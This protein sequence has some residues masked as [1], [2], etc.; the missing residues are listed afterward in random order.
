MG[1]ESPDELPEHCPD[2]GESFSVDH[3][4]AC[5]K[6]AWI[7]KRHEEVKRAWKGLFDKISDTV[8]YEPILPQGVSSG[9]TLNSTSTEFGARADIMVRGLYQPQQNAY[10]DVAVVDTGCRSCTR[11]KAQTV[12]HEREERKRRKY[13]ERLHR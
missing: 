7:G 5:K 4:L 10:L 9:I 3:A 11:M 1:L 13:K 2:C 6:G 12:L 8:V